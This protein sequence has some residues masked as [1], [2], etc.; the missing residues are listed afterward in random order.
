MDDQPLFRGRSG[1][2]AMLVIAVLVL[3]TFLL[4]A[5]R[6]EPQ[7]RPSSTY[8]AGRFGTKAFAELL[9]ETGFAVE[10]VRVPVAESPPDPRATVILIAARVD[11][12]DEV[13]LRS[14]VSAG[15]RLVLLGSRFSRS[16]DPIL[17]L[18][19]AASFADHRVVFPELPATAEVDLPV[20]VDAYAADAELLP[21][22]GSADGVLAGVGS[23][24]EGLVLL[25]ADSRLVENEYVGQADNAAVAVGLVGDPS[26]PVLILEYPHGFTRAEGLAALPLNWRWAL[27]IAALAAAAWMVGRGR[28]L[29][30]PDRRHR[31]LP[32]PRVEYVNSMA[33]GLARTGDLGGALAPLR[34]QLEHEVSSYSA[35]GLADDS[36]A[37]E[38]VG[39]RL[40]LDPGDVRRALRQSN[41]PE[42][43]LAVGRVLVALSQSRI[44]RGG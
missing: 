2:V 20:P 31:R 34:R 37:L 15:G 44:R 36:T 25:F 40:Q 23:I 13:A 9:R 16:V 33:S 28:Q 18:I 11:S 21:L 6:P 42:D 5:R 35:G 7:D 39:A 12:A 43:A 30:P 41:N 10:Q 1:V 17:G 19:P 29:G 27:G 38:S 8:S 24:D 4:G 26:R 22:L 14:F 32:P 3:I